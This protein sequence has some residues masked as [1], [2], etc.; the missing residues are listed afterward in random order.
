MGE[1]ENHRKE[2]SFLSF[3]HSLK[4]L[5]LL[6]LGGIKGNKIRFHEIFTETPKISLKIP[7]LF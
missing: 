1:N 6:K 7:F 5:F 2:Y 3:P 4:F